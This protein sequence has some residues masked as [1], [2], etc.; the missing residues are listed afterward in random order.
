ME[1][2]DQQLGT[3]YRAPEAKAEQGS[4]ALLDRAMKIKTAVYHYVGTEAG[5][6]EDLERTDESDPLSLLEEAKRKFKD[7]NVQPISKRIPQRV[8]YKTGY[9]QYLNRFIQQRSL[10]LE[11]LFMDEITEN[12][13]QWMKEGLTDEQIAEKLYLFL[14]KTLSELNSA[15][16]IGM[17]AETERVKT[18]GL[19]L[20]RYVNNALTQLAKRLSFLPRKKSPS[21]T[22][23][24]ADSERSQSELELLGCLNAVRFRLVEKMAEFNRKDLSLIIDQLEDITETGRETKVEGISVKDV[25]AFMAKV[26]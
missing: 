5:F 26:A 24:S 4:E 9:F 17:T 23:N 11:T 13:G 16:N 8:R 20:M 12:I 1:T 14:L 19:S 10:N 18:T 7:I 22:T 3:S 2:L 21:Y 15:S 6:M 25:R